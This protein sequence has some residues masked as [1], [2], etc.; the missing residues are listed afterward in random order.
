MQ[1]NPTSNQEQF[2]STARERYQIKLN[3]E[4]GLPQDQWTKDP[5]FKTWRFCNVHREDDKTTI[6]FRK[7]I[8]ESLKDNHLISCRAYS[9]YQPPYEDCT[10]EKNPQKLI[11]IL[12][13]TLIFR[14]FNRI[15]T[16]M[17]IKDLLVYDWDTAIARD[18]LT[19]ISP[20]VTG[21][22][23]IK[24]GDG[25]SKLEGILA[26]ID[27]ARP[28]LSKFIER[29]E[30]IRKEC[31]GRGYP[32]QSSLQDMWKEIKT[33]NYMGGFMAYEAVSDLRWTPVLEDA[34]DTMTWANAGPG[35]ARGLGWIMLNDS[36]YFNCGPKSQK[37]MLDL[38]R[39]LLE[40][41][42]DQMYWPQQWKPWE[43]REV[44]HW[45]CEFDKY[46][47]AESGDSLKRRF[48]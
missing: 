46:K 18:R 37:I 33:L 34:V 19:D 27:Q 5:H 6:W 21:A 9:N 32:P 39:Q 20:I 36:S 14:W 23:I 13:A 35:C 44:E 25:V 10:C 15:E 16:G 11:K 7:N 3:R 38:M 1:L 28:Q 4:A 2:F 26:C 12:E 41:S 22:Y 31:V 8:R 40:L 29:Q 42:K 48:K 43:M 17:M 24:A 45:C 30:L 47:R